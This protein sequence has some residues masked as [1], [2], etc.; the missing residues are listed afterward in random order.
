MN[1]LHT[2][3][4]AEADPASAVCLDGGTALTL[5]QFRARVAAIARALAAGEPGRPCAGAPRIAISTDDPYDFAC[6]LFAAMAIGAEAVI[7]ASATPG[8]L[9]ELKPAYDVLLD[10]A[11]L[12]AIGDAAA[13][14]QPAPPATIAADAAITL[15][16][17]GSSGAAKPV[18]KTLA[19]FDAEVRTLQAQWGAQIGRAATLSSVPHHHI[20]GLLFRILWPLASGRAFDR[21]S[22]SDPAGW[23]AR[24]LAHGDTVV[25]STPSQLARWPHLPE[26]AAPDAAGA[27]V[28]Q[29]L[30]FFSSGGPLASDTAQAYAAAFGMAPLEIFGSTETG[31][32]AW[33]RQDQAESWQP[34][35]G[36][37]V[38]RDDDGALSLRSA[39]LGHDDW[40]RTDDSI[41]LD[42]DGRFA[43]TGRLDRVVKLDGKRVS[44]PQLEARIVEH[45]FIAQA[46]ATRVDGA[47]RER[48]GVVAVLSE[49]GETA[50]REQGR[51]AVAAT[52]R[53]DLGG[54]FDPAALP[55]HWR[56]RLAMPFD[57]RGKLPAAAIAAAFAPAPEGYER[58]AEWRDAN[59][60]HAE[61]RVPPSLA[62][63]AGHFPG[64]PI[65][66]G[67]VQID[68][69][70]RIARR[71]IVAFD[72][73]RSVEHLKFKAPVLPGAVLVLSLAHDA[74][75]R[76]VRFAFRLGE[77]DCTSGALVYAE[78]P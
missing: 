68:W 21:A 59:G 27:P 31:G 7:P 9:D 71:E 56:F 28:V 23:R 64:C 66:P 6:A 41:R 67:V 3:L 17:S 43:L 50:L 40:H 14:T 74:E 33:R 60:W 62:H 26:F 12:A 25:V 63:F 8:Y 78:T 24:T 55:R 57:A 58:L 2:L 72:A 53:R 49:A 22:S 20:Y 65:L 75:R 11:R 61:L 15:Y 36:I 37:A 70:V 5:A 54:Y 29:P 38:R 44:L 19:Q 13:D 10:A 32:I 76:R 51:L 35:A 48:I 30:R 42:A 52:L 69:A 34:L 73:V 47:S 16:T 18:R 45:R 77:R 46:A 39:H 1:A 4:H